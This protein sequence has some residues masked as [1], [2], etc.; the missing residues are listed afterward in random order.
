MSGF[1]KNIFLTKNLTPM[2]E[3]SLDSNLQFE[4]QIKSKL[5]N[6]KKIK[7]QNFNF[8]NNFSPKY[9][10]NL[11]LALQ[12][13]YRKPKSQYYTPYNNTKIFDKYFL[14]LH[15]RSQYKN[16]K[17]KNLLSKKKLIDTFPNYLKTNCKLN[18][19]RKKDKSL[20]F[21]SKSLFTPTK[22]NNKNRLNNF[23]S[24]RINNF[25]K[26]MFLNKTLFPFNQKIN[27]SSTSSKNKHIWILNN[28]LQK[29]TYSIK[30]F[31]NKNNACFLKLKEKKFEF[32]NN[33]FTTLQRHNS[34]NF[35]K[36][37]VS[38][39]VQK[40]INLPKKKNL[41]LNSFGYAEKTMEYS[42]Y[43]QSNTLI[44]IFSK[45]NEPQKFLIKE[46]FTLNFHK[47]YFDNL[48]RFNI[49]ILNNVENCYLKILNNFFLKNRQMQFLVLSNNKSYKKNYNWLFQR[50]NIIKQSM[51]SKFT[52]K[53]FSIN[54][55]EKIFKKYLV[56]KFSEKNLF[57]SKKPITSFLKI[58]FSNKLLNSQKSIA[59]T[60]KLFSLV[61]THKPF[62]NNTIFKGSVLD[63]QNIHFS[64]NRKTDIKK[65]KILFSYNKTSNIFLKK[66]KMKNFN[67]YKLKAKKTKKTRHSFN[68]TRFQKQKYIQKKRRQKK[69]KGRTRRRKK[70]KRFFPRP[71]LSRY[72]LYKNFLKVR[73]FSNVNVEKIRLNLLYNP[74]EFK[75]N[76]STSLKLTRSTLGINNIIVKN[77]RRMIKKTSIN[78]LINKE[79]FQEY[80]FQNRITNLQKFFNM[81]VNYLNEQ[82]Y[83]IPK[84][85][86]IKR[87]LKSLF[88]YKNNK[89]QKLIFFPSVTDKCFS[90]KLNNIFISSKLSSNYSISSFQNRI[91]NIFKRIYLSEKNLSNFEKCKYFLFSLLGL[92]YISHFSYNNSD[93]F[94]NNII[95][96]NSHPL[97]IVFPCNIKKQP[98]LIPNWYINIKI[99]PTYFVSNSPFA[100]FFYI[101]KTS[102]YKSILNNRINTTFKNFLT[103][104]GKNKENTFFYKKKIT[105]TFVTQKQIGGEE[106]LK[107]NEFEK[108]LT[109]YSLNPTYSP[110]F[111]GYL[112]KIRFLWSLNKTNMW[113]FHKKNRKK[114]VWLYYKT[115]KQNKT[116]KS[117]KLIKQLLNTFQQKS[118][119]LNISSKLTKKFLKL[120]ELGFH[121]SSIYTE[122]KEKQIKF[123]SR[124]NVYSSRYEKLVFSNIPLKSLSLN[125][126]RKSWWTEFF[127]NGSNMLETNKKN[128]DLLCNFVMKIDTP[129]RLFHSQSILIQKQNKNLI[130]TDSYDSLVNKKLSSNELLFLSHSLTSKSIFQLQSFFL[131]E[132]L[133]IFSLFLKITLFI[134]FCNIFEVR[135]ILKFSLLG[136]YKILKNYCKFTYEFFHILTQFTNKLGM[137]NHL[138]N[139]WFEMNIPNSIFISPILNGNIIKWKE[140]M[141]NL[142]LSKNFSCS[143]EQLYLRNIS[144]V[145]KL[146]Y[147]YRKNLS[148]SKLWKNKEYQKTEMIQTQPFI[149]NSAFKKL[150]FKL[151]INE[152][153]ESR[154]MSNPLISFQNLNESNSEMSKKEK[155]QN[156]E[157]KKYL[158]KN[159]IHELNLFSNNT[160]YF[161]NFKTSIFI[162]KS[163]EEKTKKKYIWF[164][165]KDEYQFWEQN[166]ILSKKQKKHKLGFQKFHFPLDPSNW[167]I[168]TFQFWIQQQIYIFNVIKNINILNI[169]NNRLN[170]QYYPTNKIHFISKQNFDE[171]KYE[172]N[173][174]FKNSKLTKQFINGITIVNIRKKGNDFD[175]TK[176]FISL[177]TRQNFVNLLSKPINQ[178]IPTLFHRYFNIYFN[179]SFLIVTQIFLYIFQN[180]FLFFSSFIFKFIDML[181]IF[182]MF[183]YKSLEKQTE[184]VINWMA[185]GFV[186]E[187][188]SDVS[189]LI[190]DNFDIYNWKSLIKSNRGFR[191]FGPI[192]MFFENRIKFLF[193]NSL[194]VLTRYDSDLLIREKKGLI[195]W[196]VWSDILIKAAEKYNINIPSL[197]N[198]KDEQEL[199]VTKMLEDE[200][201]SWN[202][203]DPL[204][205]EYLNQSIDGMIPKKWYQFALEKDTSKTFSQDPYR[206]L[207]LLV[208]DAKSISKNLN[209][210]RTIVMNNHPPYLDN[211]KNNKD[212]F[213]NENELS[214]LSQEL[215]TFDNAIFKNQDSRNIVKIPFM[216]LKSPLYQTK[217]YSTN[218]SQYILPTFKS[219]SKF[220][221]E[222]YLKSDI[223][224][225]KKKLTKKQ[226]LF[227]F[228]KKSDESWN[229]WFYLQ[230]FTFQGKDTDFFIDIHPPKSFSHLSFIKY[231]EAG[232]E[233]IGLL[234]CQ[235]YSGTFLKQVSKNFLVLGAPGTE[236]SLLVQALAGETEIQII[237]DNSRRYALVYRGIALGIKLLKDVFAAIAL[238]TPCLFLLEE[239]HIIGEKRTQL[240]S[241]DENSKTTESYLGFDQNEIHEKNQ[242]IYQLTKH[243][244]C[245]YKKPYKGDFSTLIPTHEFCFN[246]FINNSLLKTRQSFLTP[247]NPLKTDSNLFEFTNEYSRF[248]VNKYKNLNSTKNL[249]IL[250]TR[251][252]LSSEKIF[253]PPATS[254]FNILILKEQKKLRKNQRVKEVSWGGTVLEKTNIFPQ[255]TYSIKAKIA[256]LANMALNNL[257]VKL[258]IITDLLIIIDT[259]R[260]HRGFAVFATTHLPSLLDPALRRP[261]RLDD[262]ITLPQK[263]SLLNK[264][265]ILNSNFAFKNSTVDLLNYCFHFNNFEN[266]QISEIISRLKLQLFKQYSENNQF[267]NT[268]VFKQRKKLP[269]TIN[270]KNEKENTKAIK[271]MN[272][273]TSCTTKKIVNWIQPLKTLLGINIIDSNFISKKFL[274]KDSAIYKNSIHHNFQNI[275]KKNNSLFRK[276]YL[277][278]NNLMLNNDRNYNKTTPENFS[279]LYFITKTK[280]LLTRFYF[281]K[282]LSAR[283]SK[284]LAYIYHQ[285]GLTLINAYFL[286]NLKSYG[287]HFSNFL[288][289][290]KHI[291]TNVF[292]HFYVSSYLLKYHLTSLLSGKIAELFLFSDSKVVFPIVNKPISNDINSEKFEKNNRNKK[293]CWNSLNKNKQYFQGLWSLYGI[294]NIWRSSYTFFLSL[295]QKRYLYHKSYVISRLFYIENKT[296]LKDPLGPPS[297]SLFLPGRKY[298]NLK[299]LEALF[300]QKLFL[301]ISE[302]LKI[303]E[304]QRFIK[305]LYNKTIQNKFRSELKE[306]YFSKNIKTFC[307]N[308]KNEKENNLENRSIHSNDNNFLES[309]SNLSTNWSTSLRELIH[310]QNSMRIPMATN[311][312][313]K[314]KILLRHKFYLKNQ[315]WNGHL[316]EQNRET[317]FLSDVDWRSLFQDSFGDILID[318]PDPDQYYNP[319]TRR[320]ILNNGFWSYWE[321][322]QYPFYNEIYY[323]F[324]ME[325]FN[326]AL[327]FL[328]SQ[329]EMLD[330]FSYLGLKKNIG[331]EINFIQNNLKFYLFLNN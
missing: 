255:F 233:P 177:T 37:D 145:I 56:S 165:S 287:I 192:G 242:V 190:P 262:T 194:Q 184:L 119:R 36:N 209:I 5:N 256:M 181:E 27:N 4:T 318:F 40:E 157:L 28:K 48:K 212:Q 132:S 99:F 13:K 284:I 258:D 225:R 271:L 104:N 1:S 18:Q 149:S 77:V 90:K 206:Q 298:E 254:P 47:K 322:F 162:K 114:D 267:F 111:L 222:K 295:I 152:K 205:I 76:L 160:N 155:I 17:K 239:I 85:N 321:N 26:F 21:G 136:I 69:Q 291:E 44:N 8:V 282:S 224:F 264:W 183:V 226:S 89:K 74:Y 236:K 129:L 98:I 214:I 227:Q 238:Y 221:S 158:R 312:C 122:K 130:S 176:S 59:D 265:E 188:S 62:R 273:K 103:S 268:Q 52:S 43:L 285:Q 63:K 182:G 200:S 277:Y 168:K 215:Q 175:T 113:M 102:N 3:V 10:K 105:K 223:L 283:P 219:L 180:S 172:I 293:I 187:W 65:E 34:I 202:N 106:S 115:R 280:Q 50:Q 208:N 150:I 313:N 67:S 257:S 54:K 315:W 234:T 308:L 211:K 83:Q 154:E 140:Q 228:F 317:T 134:F 164:T 328:N 78:S 120:K 261:G 186:I 159:L 2:T 12:I 250:P 294:D 33:Q 35:F 272:L 80:N 217:Q 45:E 323:H 30:N 49:E 244:L 198:L 64:S 41:K 243:A 97:S 253:A 55:I 185:Y 117:K 281:S 297:S 109:N 107:T 166:K 289:N 252:Q 316:A 330:Y 275:D 170:F 304:Q 23:S 174:I 331:T 96:S 126:S 307:S 230:Y 133:F 245:D 263:S 213:Y 247:K 237:V 288:Q 138:L 286:K 53:T 314:Q 143:I 88:L 16:E 235:I 20:D 299:R 79:A 171:N 246:L 75:N 276:K 189:V 148:S 137:S 167:L 118:I 156:L 72:N 38:S 207:K 58:K 86:G 61:T 260:S 125:M 324:T 29:K 93:V 199:L 22:T 57:W 169:A 306:I 84:E 146:E 259:T 95:Y 123:I 270:A 144:S 269:L 179:L 112:P 218:I 274:M 196:N 116:N 6:E 216:N 302:K 11:L 31:L 66:I 319:R 142:D 232:L 19:K 100:K 203:I 311:L 301:S 147:L 229:R 81:K 141:F 278:Q 135:S 25:D 193:L 94:K 290:R 87:D 60:L 251:L 248:D 220:A 204:E 39:L 91:K 161:Q 51:I 124:K 195:F 240:I 296:S 210:S 305:K 110:L 70:R 151:E 326:T 92:E 309:K 279:R 191:F 163:L 241:D 127:I 300:Q 310:L 82:I 266:I 71:L 131:I 178:F 128:T 68:I 327:S 325:C 7:K 46:L 153:R 201:W 32:V 9:N 173:T 15:K 24:F 329:R 231:S 73:L 139:Y 197:A 249:K 303:H 101:Q 42:K 108:F 320:W 121:Y 292:Q 14:S